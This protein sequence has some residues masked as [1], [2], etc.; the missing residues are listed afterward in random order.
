MTGRP[1][2]SFYRKSVCPVDAWDSP[3]SSGS[4]S[5]ALWTFQSG[6]HVCRCL[7]AI[8]ESVH[9]EQLLL[10]Y[11]CN[12]AQ[13][14]ITI[15]T[16]YSWQWKRVPIQSDLQGT[17]NLLTLYRTCTNFITD[18]LEISGVMLLK[19]WKKQDQI[20]YP[21]CFWCTLYDTMQNVS[22]CLKTDI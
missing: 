7:A 22:A 12:Y 6:K 16:R 19:I 5:A 3:L 10:H 2:V 15:L 8:S 11:F 13:S 9:H 1:A 20:N 18:L 21:A 17:F 14:S 4:H